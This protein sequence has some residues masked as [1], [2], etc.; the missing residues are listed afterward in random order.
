MEFQLKELNNLIKKIK[1]KKIQWQNMMNH[2]KMYCLFF[3]QYILFANQINRSKC[4]VKCLS[5]LFSLVILYPF[6]K[7][8][9]CINSSKTSTT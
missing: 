8:L 6:T 2:R 4:A 3:G 1:E 5:N 7:C 9:V